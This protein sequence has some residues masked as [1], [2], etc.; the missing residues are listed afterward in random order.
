MTTTVIKTLG[1]AGGRD[2][3]SVAAWVAAAPANLVTA[4]QVWKGE[5][6]NDSNSFVVAGAFDISGP[7]TDAT[8]FMWL[9]AAAGQSFQDHANKLTNPVRYDQTKGV[10]LESTSGFGSDAFTMGCNFTL[11]ERLQFKFNY[12]S[13]AAGVN[14]T[15]SNTLLKNCICYRTVAYTGAS[16]NVHLYHAS[17]V[18]VNVVSI[19]DRQPLPASAS[20]TATPRRSTA[21]PLAPLPRQVEVSAT[22]IPIRWCVTA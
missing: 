22:S 14:M 16:G 9:T 2:Y 17:S 5:M 13:H 7:T 4:D 15:G 20:R 21:R 19:D 12:S 10:G 8:R 3:T 6:Y 11:V 18:A 1:S